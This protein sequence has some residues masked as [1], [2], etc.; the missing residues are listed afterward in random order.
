MDFDS[1]LPRFRCAGTKLD[2]SHT[3]V[4][5]ATA[6]WWKL[7]WTLYVMM[8]YLCIPDSARPMHAWAEGRRK[9][10]GFKKSVTVWKCLPCRSDFWSCDVRQRISKSWLRCKWN[11]LK[12]SMHNCQMN[13]WINEPVSRWVNEPN[14]QW[15]NEPAVQRAND[16]V[17]HCINQW[18]D[19]SADPWVSVVSTFK[20]SLDQWSS[21]ETNGWWV[22]DSMNQ[23]IKAS[24]QWCF[25]ESKNESWLS[26]PMNP[27]STWTK[28]SEMV[29][30]WTNEWM[31]WMER[32]ARME[33]MEWLEWLE[34]LDDLFAEVP[35]VS[36][37]LLL[38]TASYLRRCVTSSLTLPWATSQ[39]PNSSLRTAVSMR[40]ET[41]SCD[42]AQQERRSIT[43]ALL[44]VTMPIR[45]LS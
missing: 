19:D 6:Q 33:W 22:N 3:H 15:S 20:E 43:P 36:A 45:V 10:N 7:K 34:W 40:L 1:V 9:W 5:G 18:T 29:S 38:W 4:L 35:L 32:L 28:R 21:E 24:I 17:N 25:S 31:E 13:Q 27:W 8:N 14:N 16:S 44:C 39:K 30:R 42:P 12:E 11:D 26:E 41:F 23:W 2:S 37:I